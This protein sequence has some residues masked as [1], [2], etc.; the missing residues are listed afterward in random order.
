MR[1]NGKLIKFSETYNMLNVLQCD[2]FN[3][4]CR[5]VGGVSG[6][7]SGGESVNMGV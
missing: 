2:G 1:I 5:A 4:D 3:A 7:V 6:D